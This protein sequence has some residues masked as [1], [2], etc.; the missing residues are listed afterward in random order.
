M[1]LMTTDEVADFFRT[2]P[3]TVR[4]W[5]YIS[6]GPEGRQVGRRVLYDPHAVQAF[7][8]RQAMAGD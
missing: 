4:Y 3:N 7:W 8:D 1:R 2:S 6:Y 5:R